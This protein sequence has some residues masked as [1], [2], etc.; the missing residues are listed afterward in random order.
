MASC[1]WVLVPVSTKV[2]EPFFTQLT[3]FAALLVILP[4]KVTTPFRS[5][6]VNARTRPAVFSLL[7]SRARVKVR[8]K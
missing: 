4:E 2:P 8:L 6:V 3:P 5:E 1:A 7:I